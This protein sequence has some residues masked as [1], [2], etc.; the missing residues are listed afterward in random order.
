MESSLPGEILPRIWDGWRQY[1]L[2]DCANYV[3]KMYTWFAICK[4]AALVIFF[5][6][7]CVSYK[8]VRL[9]DTTVTLLCACKLTSLLV[10]ALRGNSIVLKHDVEARKWQIRHATYGKSISTLIA[11]PR[12][13]ILQT[14]GHLRDAQRHCFQT[15]VS[16]RPMM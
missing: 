13:I 5:Q 15:R 1:C 12:Q 11:Q 7:L 16:E 9:A 8:L 2:H 14:I 4:Y 10:L 3:G 6:F